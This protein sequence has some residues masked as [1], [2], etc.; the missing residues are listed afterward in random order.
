MFLKSSRCKSEGGHGGPDPHPGEHDPPQHITTSSVVRS[1]VA[2]LS[3]QSDGV[4]VRTVTA[5]LLV[6]NSGVSWAS[7]TDVRFSPP[8]VWILRED[9]ITGSSHLDLL[10]HKHDTS[11]ATTSSEGKHVKKRQEQNTAF[12]APAV[13]NCC[14]QSVNQEEEEEVKIQI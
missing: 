7:K 6:S 9:K 2:F 3:R 14:L 4:F 10:Y 8:Q 11:P 13:T 5:L 12:P 1:S